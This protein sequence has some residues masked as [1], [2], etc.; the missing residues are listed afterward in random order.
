M[1]K[2][3]DAGFPDNLH[4]QTAG[5]VQMALAS[6][7]NERYNMVQNSPNITPMSDSVFTSIQTGN[8]SFIPEFDSRI[9]R[10]LAPR[11]LH[12]IGNNFYPMPQNSIEELCAFLGVDY[13]GSNKLSNRFD[14]KWAICRY[15]I[16]NKMR[17]Y[18]RSFY[19]EWEYIVRE[20]YMDST[21]PDKE[22]LLLGKNLG[23][24]FAQNYQHKHDLFYVVEKQIETVLNFNNPAAFWYNS[25]HKIIDLYMQ[26]DFTHDANTSYFD[27]SGGN[28]PEGALWLVREVKREDEKIPIFKKDF[29]HETYNGD[30]G[31]YPVVTQKYTLHRLTPEDTYYPGDLWGHVDSAS[32]VDIAK[33]L[34]YYDPPEN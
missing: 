3:Q 30:W 5:T 4:L 27:F 2:W 17:Y 16:L 1:S 19:L 23:A 32:F 12:K 28:A 9:I 7:L 13:I 10:E 25:Y 15:N 34:Q 8:K 20:K 24:F 31:L 33:S 18:Q 11:F 26:F 14:T 6:A 21:I 22:E 29:F